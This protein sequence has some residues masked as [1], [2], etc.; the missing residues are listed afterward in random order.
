MEKYKEQWIITPKTTWLG[1][2]IRELIIHKDLLFGIVRKD[3]LSSYQQTLL[4]PLWIL[5]QPLF[6]VIVYMFVFN[7]L[8]GVS[9]MGVPP[10]LFYLAGITLWNLFSDLFTST[11]SV[12][13][14]N[15]GVFSKVYFPRLITPLA[16]LL[17]HLIR[18]SVHF[19]FLIV[20]LVFFIIKG[21][22][23]FDPLNFFPVIVS[24]LLVAFMAFGGGLIFSVI[25]TKYRD[26]GGFMQ[27]MIRLLL[28]VTPVFYTLSNVPEKFSWVL[29]INPLTAPFEMFRSALT[30][31]LVVMPSLALSLGVT[32]FIVGSG[33]LLFNKMT[34]RLM[35]I[36]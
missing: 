18:F 28:F 21:K 12:I 22:I 13:A 10:F 5:I 19:I 2:G 29:Q 4:G 8:I 30:G 3:L 24:I 1:T 20:V 16:G 11:S 27:M 26:I 33:I 36:A 15:I 7:R 34:D 35:D 31:E 23:V 25:S 17:L 32:F 14:N 9:T 6:S